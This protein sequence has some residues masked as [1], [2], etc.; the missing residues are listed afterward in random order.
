VSDPLPSPP[1]PLRPDHQFDAF[2][3]DVPALDQWLKR[4]ALGNEAGGASR[5]FVSCLEDRVVG[6][7]SLAAAS[8]VHDV[9]TPRA[10]RNM[11]DPVPAVVLGRLAVD[12][13]MQGRRLGASLLQD[14]ILRVAAAADAIGVRVLLVHALSDD[15][16]RFYLKHGFRESPVEPMTLMVTL[17]ELRREI[18][19]SSDLGG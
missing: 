1:A 11:P 4:R 13:R 3:S 12:K 19:G 16:K 2:D 18:G 5:T 8:V 6:Y 10:R 9:A 15:A 14:A 7:Y 17:E